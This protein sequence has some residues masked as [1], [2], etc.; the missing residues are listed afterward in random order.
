VA[1]N[2][3]LI[4]QAK[5]AAQTKTADGWLDWLADPAA[6]SGRTLYN[7][8]PAA[9]NA[10]E[11][12][13]MFSNRAANTPPLPGKPPAPTPTLPAAPSPGGPVAA[14]SPSPAAAT[15]SAPKTPAATM[16]DTP[17]VPNR[18]AGAS[19]K[20]A[21]DTTV[22]PKKKKK[23]DYLRDAWN[24]IA[25][26]TAAAGSAMHSAATP[27]ANRAASSMSM[28][29]V[30]ALSL[31]ALGVAGLGYGAAY[32]LASDKH[33]AN[34]QQA[35]AKHNTPLQP[36][37]TYGMRYADMMSV[38]AAT[39]PFGVPYSTIS[40]AVRK[41]P[42]LL[43]LMGQNEEWIDKNNVADISG[44]AHYDDFS[45]GPAA[46]YLHN[47]LLHTLKD[48]KMP[49]GSSLSAK[50]TPNFNEYWNTWLKNHPA[51]PRTWGVVSPY[52]V[53]TEQIPHGDQ[54]LFLR[55]W[56]EQLP[57]DQRAALD[58]VDKN[59]PPKTRIQKGW[60]SNTEVP[61]RAADGQ[62]AENKIKKKLYEHVDSAYAPLVDKAI[63]F[64]QSLKDVGATALGAGAGALAGEGVYQMTANKNKAKRS[65][66]VR[67]L[68]QLTGAGIGG[69][70]T[71]ALGTDTGRKMLSN[72]VLGS[73]TKKAGLTTQQVL[74]MING[75]VLASARKVATGAYGMQNIATQQYAPI[76]ERR[77]L[78]P[79][80]HATLAQN[81][82][83][84][85]PP[86]FQ[87]YSTPMTSM[88]ASPAKA[89]V[90]G[91]VGVGALGAGL[92][93]MLGSD[94][95]S[96]L[97]GAAIGGLAG[98][99]L[100]GLGGYFARQNEND[101]L[102]E[103]LSRL[104]EGARQ[105]DMLA[106]PA[107]QAGMH[108]DAMMA[109]AMHKYSSAIALGYVLSKHAQTKAAFEL[110]SM[111]DLPPNMLQHAGI[112]A[113]GGAALGGLMGPEEIPWWKRMLGGAAM[114]GAAGAGYNQLMPGANDVSE[115]AAESVAPGLPSD[116]GALPHGMGDMPDATAARSP[117]IS[118]E[119]NSDITP[120]GFDGALARITPPWL[121]GS[122]STMPDKPPQTEINNTQPDQ[123]RE[124]L[125]RPMPP[126]PPVASSQPTAPPTAQ[127]KPMPQANPVVTNVDVSQPPPG[128]GDPGKANASPPPG[129]SSITPPWLAG[130][131]G[132]GDHMRNQSPQM[133]PGPMTATLGRP[134]PNL[135]GAAPSGGN[136]DQ[137][138][139]F[140][141]PEHLADM[142]GRHWDQARQTH[143]YARLRDMANG[144]PSGGNS[145]DMFGDM[146][147][148]R[149]AGSLAGQP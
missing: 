20:Q 140:T 106:D 56:R 88:V 84:W 58:A 44:D 122:G 77:E 97:A 83:N 2:Q 142:Q 104:P 95:G 145:G 10:A 93:G 137:F 129:M 111:P 7:A 144:P 51:Q 132:P 67:L 61:N 31:G 66:I 78:S 46:A 86:I 21:D 24:A 102:K 125:A 103:I 26:P 49:D 124:F 121:A 17:S 18:M 109:A 13:P 36:N 118:S 22:D 107:V 143:N 60:V 33:V 65:A 127:P 99:G 32:G 91:A 113:L 119:L 40:Q 59:D 35:M 147:R 16:S 108:R 75:D 25:P 116:I 92:G 131:Q 28:P 112:G 85:L 149:R 81:E 5:N 138:Q 101:N 39:T 98:A 76:Q 79:T 4:E 70:G 30:P 23:P 87:N 139:G 47:S 68:A 38:P 110:P 48:S 135:G 55:S 72:A 57:K 34:I 41:N 130:G 133:P 146:I 63:G 14:A 12:S 117:A 69:A 100:G 15:R 43:K 105:R 73:Q 53:D 148:Q 62:L 6:A 50:L 90:M 123:V 27:V 141:Q 37:E 9:L 82:N 128:G 52:E 89:G 11:N 115:L 96:P 94:A 126:P 19:F 80:E 45:K 114:G 54:S 3:S 8:L 29:S 134:A 136:P 1:L 71:F 42:A 74:K 64:R 120:Q